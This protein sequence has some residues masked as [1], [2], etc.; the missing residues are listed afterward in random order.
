MKPNLIPPPPQK[1]KKNIKPNIAQKTYGYFLTLGFFHLWFYLLE[2]ETSTAKTV[3][4]ATPEFTIQEIPR[5]LRGS[6]AKTR[7]PLA[8]IGGTIKK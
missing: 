2:E 8:N 4:A 5:F 1:K 7:L 6:R 3:M